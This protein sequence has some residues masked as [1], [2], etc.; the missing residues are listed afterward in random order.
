MEAILGVI[1]SGLVQFLKR[2]LGTNEMQTLTLVGVL[3]LVGAAIY[4]SLVNAG[5]W[6]TVYQVIVTAGAFYAFILQRLEPRRS[7]V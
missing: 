1:V 7:A 3:S 2:R 6:E 5:L 4:I